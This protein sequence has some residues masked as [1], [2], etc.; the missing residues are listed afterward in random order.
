MQNYLHSAVTTTILTMMVLIYL[1]TLLFAT[2]AAVPVSVMVEN[3]ELSS[4]SNAQQLQDRQVHNN[5]DNY[6]GK[7][8]VLYSKVK[9][10]SDTSKQ[11]EA[12]THHQNVITDV[13][14]NKKSSPEIV[15][16]S[17]NNNNK[18][19]EISTPESKPQHQQKFPLQQ[20]SNSV[21]SYNDDDDVANSKNELISSIIAA[22]LAAAAVKAEL[23]NLKKQRHRNNIRNENANDEYDDNDDD[24]AAVINKRGV[25]NQQYLY[26]ANNEPLLYDNAAYYNPYGGYMAVNDD[27]LN[28]GVWGED[29]DNDNI[30][31]TDMDEYEPQRAVPNYKKQAYD[32]LQN[33]LN[34]EY[35]LDSAILP[36]NYE[37]YADLEAERNKKAYRIFSELARNY[38]DMRPKRDNKLT[39][40]D[41]LAL[42]ALVEA[43]ERAR[44]ETD[45]DSTNSYN[46]YPNENYA[47]KA[48]GMTPNAGFYDY[49]AIDDNFDYNNNNNN[50]NN[51]D[52]W[53][54]APALVDY[55][56]APV[57]ME[58]L[59]KYNLALKEKENRHRDYNDNMRARYGKKRLMVN[60]K[61]KRSLT[62]P[63]ALYKARY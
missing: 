55:Y 62:K 7:N 18:L 57:N 37:R 40:A 27:G 54:D 34:A 60:N 4:A 22:R 12:L 3:S 17:F 58:P 52:N 23:E 61:K 53:N 63:S 45:H 47:P 10:S 8:E 15:P 41:M 51:N 26:G 2:V 29:L 59:P 13:N 42:V 28:R 21:S 48:Y 39:P 46:G 6:S 25:N 24:H 1:M 50:N 56:G 32:D 49:P 33:L 35:H 44:K 14:K 16:A 38:P 9:R 20:H 30:V 43:G 19:P 36:Y 5:K 11:N 31:Y